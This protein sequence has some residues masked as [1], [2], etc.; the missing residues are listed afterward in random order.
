MTTSWHRNALFVFVYFPGSH[1]SFY[2][3]ATKSGEERHDSQKENRAP[4]SSSPAP[5]NTAAKHN[6]HSDS[7]THSA[8]KKGKHSVGH[9]GSEVRPKDAPKVE[10]QQISHVNGVKEDEEMFKGLH[11]STCKLLINLYM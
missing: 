6:G 8:A 3:L 10:T 9:N 11:S 4:Q 1:T 5:S 2:I 7:N